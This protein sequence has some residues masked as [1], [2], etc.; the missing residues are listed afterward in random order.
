M[1]AAKCG[2]GGA[3]VILMNASF[4]QVNGGLHIHDWAAN[5]KL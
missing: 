4:L 5:A 2:F 1:V 3:M